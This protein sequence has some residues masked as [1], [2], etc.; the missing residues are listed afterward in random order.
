MQPLAPHGS[1]GRAAA[2]PPLL[3]LP[4]PLVDP[5]RH[6]GRSRLPAG[7]QPRCGGQLLRALLL[8]R[9]RGAAALL[10]QALLSARGAGDKRKR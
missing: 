8:A 7:A 5:R 1:T 2:S 6:R 9:L 3:R 4:Q 10:L